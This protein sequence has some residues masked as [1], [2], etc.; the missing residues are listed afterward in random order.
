MLVWSAVHCLPRLVVC[1][2]PDIIVSRSDGFRLFAYPVTVGYMAIM[3]S[4]G[5]P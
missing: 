4:G 2:H 1:I 5:S 3:S